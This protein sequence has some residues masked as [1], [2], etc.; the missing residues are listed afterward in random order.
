MKKRISY[1]SLALSLMLTVSA[2]GQADASA[3]TASDSSA[4]ELEGSK[5]NTSFNVNFPDFDLVNGVVGSGFAEDLLNEAYQYANDVESHYT[6]Q[7]FDDATAVKE[8]TISSDGLSNIKLESVYGAL[9][10]EPSPDANIH[11]KYPEEAHFTISHEVVD[12]DL[13]ISAKVSTPSNYD[14]L[15]VYIPLDI[16]KQLDIIEGASSIHLIGQEGMLESCNIEVALASIYLE[17]V[18]ADTKVKT[19]TGTIRMSNDTI[20]SNIYLITKTGAI[21]LALGEVPDDVSIYSNGNSVSNALLEGRGGISPNEKY[22][23]TLENSVGGINIHK[24]D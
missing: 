11:L 9:Y 6:E 17:N 5:M 24:A 4:S 23:V 2:C 16:I 20:K 1:I 15:K 8:E 13:K 19:G 18:Y 21:D 12:G 14:V 7:L 3:S 22:A 10:I